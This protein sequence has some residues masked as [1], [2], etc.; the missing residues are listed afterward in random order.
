MLK[1]FSLLAI[2]LSFIG[3]NT[4]I[5]ANEKI[6]IEAF[7]KL[8]DVE[9]VELSPTAN[10]LAILKRTLVEG[11]RLLVLE[12]SDFATGKKSYPVIRRN[13]EF[14]VA[15]LIWASDRHILLR[16]DFFK[17]LK[18]E[19][20]GWNPYITERRLMVLDLETNTLKN[21][22]SKMAFKRFE[23]KGWQPQFQD[24]I[25]DLLPDEPNYILHALDWNARVSP[26]VFKVNLS[27]LERKSVESQKQN[28]RSFIADRQGNVR[29]GTFRESRGG[30]IA[31]NRLQYEVNVK[32]LATK[33]WE[34]LWSYAYGD[35][36][37]VSP[38]GFMTDPNFL[39]VEALHENRDA[40]FKVDLRKPDQKELFYSEPTRNVGGEIYYSPKSGEPVGYY[41]GTAIHFWDEKYKAFIKGINNAL[42]HTNNRLLSLNNDENKYLVYSESDVDSGTYYLGDR[43]AKSLNPVAY[44]Y[45]ALDP[46]QL[47]KSRKVL[48]DDKT[49]NKEMTNKGKI[50]VFVTNPTEPQSIKPKPTIIYVNQ[51][52]GKASRGG[53]NDKVQLLAHQGYQVIQANFKYSRFMRGDIS[54]WGDELYQNINEVLHWA[55]TEK[56]IEDDNVCLLGET[57][58]GW[59][60]LMAIAKNKGAYKCVATIGAMTDILAQVSAHEGF[61][62]YERVKAQLSDKRAIQKQYS[63]TTYTDSFS[64]PALI[65]HG[66]SDSEVR[67]KQGQ[68]F[69]KALKRAKNDVE[70]IEI[71][72][73]D[74]SLTTDKSR[75]RVY[76]KL[77][78]FFDKHLS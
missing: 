23:K 3:I 57:Y 4:D 67:S 25:V 38:L 12:I 76:K 48:V 69:Y 19:N 2:V 33:K 52:V 58:A 24:Q 70:Y 27:T 9:L 42:A 7:A 60:A 59:A 75:I 16:I 13:N 74:S 41:S 44:R 53:F 77:I 65:I 6:P 71:K 11:K 56:M 20:T 68:K 36:D 29:V 49:H 26:K 54:Q 66:E 62:E 31:R 46:I 51:G 10:K 17:Q 73:E 45:M 72:N 18:I 15:E 63:P 55:K 39:L 34:T 35:E 78:D 5:L 47:A 30:A 43:K 22:I 37:A 21:I 1:T 32:N 61:V 64:T 50:K 40:I 8:P 14:E 28:W